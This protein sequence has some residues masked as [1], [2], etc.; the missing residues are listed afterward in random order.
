M[1][2]GAM[3]RFSAA[4]LLAL[5]CA[6][7]VTLH[8]EGMDDALFRPPHSAHAAIRAAHRAASAAGSAAAV[9]HKSD[10]DDVDAEAATPPAPPAPP[11]PHDIVS[12]WN[13][14]CTFNLSGTGPR[15]IFPYEHEQNTT[16]TAFP[17]VSERLRVIVLLLASAT[18]RCPWTHGWTTS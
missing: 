5:P 9:V 18:S 15:L 10:D 17:V 11:K 3:A 8:E 1:A 14:G 6:L 7:G 13:A 2:R 16:T 12:N 4:L